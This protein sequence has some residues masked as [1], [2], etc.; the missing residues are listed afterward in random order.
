MSINHIRIATRQSPL[1]IWQAEFVK[2]QL[3][4]H[5]PQLHVDLVKISTQGDNHQSQALAEIG[6]KSLFVKELQKALLD[7]KA[8][9]AVHSI[10]DMSV[11]EHPELM[12]G[13]ILKRANPCD[14]FVSNTAQ[15]F[16]ELSH[17]AII[18]TASP[19]RQAL[20]Q[21]Y[22]PSFS[23][24]LLRGNINT[25][26]HKL[27]QGDYEAIILAAAGLERLGLTHR[28]QAYLPKEL[29]TPA[30]GQ[31]AL[32][33]ECCRQHSDLLNL[34]SP[35]HDDLTAYC[36]HAEQAVNQQL[37]G[38]CFT[39]IG[40]HATIDNGILSLNAFVADKNGRVLLRS[41]RQGPPNEAKTIGLEVANDLI[42]QGAL[43]LI[44][45]DQ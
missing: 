36:V 37:G 42:Q 20:I 8:D 40:A 35:L 33:I 12:L 14:A 10:K 45:H 25:R 31:G 29:F 1:A 15:S 23:I 30:I 24:K 3:I 13:A 44:H 11:Q 34:I 6:G 22:Y 41:Q 18:G 28:I 17:H 43:T 39:P 21:S 27:D 32:G 5:H 9:I 4:T 19:R 38:S 26:L 16:D 7:N 2:Q